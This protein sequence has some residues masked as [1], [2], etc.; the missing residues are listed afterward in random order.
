MRRRDFIKVVAGSAITW[1]LVAGAQQPRVP[2]IGF[3]NSASP[4]SFTRHMAAFRQG[5]SETGYAEDQNVA[6]E[7]RWAEGQYDR[8]PALA[9]DLVNRKVAVVVTAG[10]PAAL[11][12]KASTTAIPI[13]FGMGYD[14]VQYGLVASLNRPG[15]NVT[16]VIF[17]A[18]T[19]APKRL[20]LLHEIVPT[21]SV[22]ALLVNP[23]TPT[24]EGQ[25]SDVRAAAH[26]L[27]WA[28]HVFNVGRNSDFDGVFANMN[29]R[30]VA[31][32][33]VGGDP[34]FFSSQG[35]IIAFAAR[36]SLPAIYDRREYAEAGGLMSYGTSLIDVYRQQ[37]IYTGRILKGEKPAD[38]P[39]IQPT[40]FELVINLKTAKT[41]GLT[42][43]ASFL[44]LADD[45]IN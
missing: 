27:G 24:S 3:L 20:Q 28:L 11:A 21:A 44:S 43:P 1:P 10:P 2:V 38:L 22:V 25:V 30:G 36:Y 23:N 7:Y 15:G 17:F 40:T 29:E 6:I 9:A 32:L 41:L 12:A 33:I 14:P 34:L 45:L 42:I 5:L 39:V 37:G 8:L 35:Q 31:A 19:L 16:G 13:V 18:G 26:A 4:G